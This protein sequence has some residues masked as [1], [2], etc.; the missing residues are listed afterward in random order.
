MLF[1][2]KELTKSAFS[3]ITKRFYER[4]RSSGMILALVARGP[5]FE[6]WNAPFKKFI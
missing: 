5:E 6:S 3:S 1:L 4:R 2:W